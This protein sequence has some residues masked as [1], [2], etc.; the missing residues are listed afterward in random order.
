MLVCIQ[1]RVF[2]WPEMAVSSSAAAVTLSSLL[3]EKNQIRRSIYLYQVGRL[4]CTRTRRASTLSPVAA[5]HC[6]LAS[7]AA[8]A[9]AAVPLS[10]KKKKI[11]IFFCKKKAVRPEGNCHSCCCYIV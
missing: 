2:C 8:T 4:A 6:N 11:R 7:A 9:A 3:F 10:S 1:A 5:L